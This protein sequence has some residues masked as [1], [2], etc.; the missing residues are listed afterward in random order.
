VSFLS[1]DQSAKFLALPNLEKCGQ[2]PK[3][4]GNDYFKSNV[5][6]NR[7]RLSESIGQSV[8]CSWYQVRREFDHIFA[9]AFSMSNA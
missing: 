1:L 5:R 7:S 8:A 2:F 4:A 9:A 6:T 3:S